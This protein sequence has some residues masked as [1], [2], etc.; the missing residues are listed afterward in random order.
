MTTVR[1]PVRI[2]IEVAE[3]RIDG[4]LVAYVCDAVDAAVSRAVTRAQSVRAIATGRP[5]GREACTTVRFT[6]D[7][8]PR[9]IADAL[10][11]S[12][13]TGLYVAGE[14]LIRRAGGPYTKDEV[15]DTAGQGE[16]RDD[17]R[18]VFD[19]GGSAEYQVPYYDRG[20]KPMAVR[21]HGLAR[22]PPGTAQPP[23]PLPVRLRRF[24]TD[25]ELWDAIMA[26]TGGHPPAR[27]VAIRADDHGKN[28]WADFINI[29]PG[30][31]GQLSGRR[32]GAGPLNL[33][34]FP[35]GQ[36]EAVERPVGFVNADLWS[37]FGHATGR[38]QVRNLMIDMVSVALLRSSPKDPEADVRKRA[39]LVIDDLPYKNATSL[40]LY[41]LTSLGYLV[42]V[43]PVT[44]GGPIPGDTRPAL[45]FTEDDPDPPEDTYGKNCP[46]LDDS[47]PS[48]WL[49]MLGL[50]HPSPSAPE[51]PFLGEP[52]IE[53]WPTAIMTRLD[54]KVRAIA[55]MLHMA[56]GTF[57]GGFLIAALAHVDRNCRILTSNRAP[58]WPQIQAMA[59]AFLPIRE[60]YQEYITIMLSQDQVRA[61]PCPVAGQAPEWGLRFAEVFASARDDAVAS[62]FVSTCQD[63]LL[64][65][66]YA[67]SHELSSRAQSFSSYMPITRML[68]TV[69]L[70]DTVELMDLRDAVIARE[71]KEATA[72]IAT[73][74]VLGGPTIGATWL[75]F[76][77]SLLDS[78]TQEPVSREPTAGTVELHRDGYR[79]YD[80]MGQWWSRAELDAVITAQR[81]QVS[82]VD[83]LLD[84]V[85]EIDD[86]VRQLKAAQVLDANAST[87]LGHQLTAHVDDIFRDLLS[88][89]LKENERWLL[90]A[91]TDRKL[92]FGLANFTRDDVRSASDIGAK[93]AGIH[94]LADERLRPAFS[95]Q[96]AYVAGMSRLAAEE[97]GKAELT[98]ILSLVGL[99]V[100][101][102]FCPLLA[103]G[104]SLVQ[105]AEGLMT[106]F[107][108]RDLQ[109][110]MLNGDEILS[111]AQVEAEMWAAVINAA[112]TVLPELPSLARG[113]GSA[114]RA[115]VRGEATEAAAAATRQAMRNIA[116][117]L[118][119]LG[120]EHFTTRFAKELVQAY[121]I[122]LALSKAMNRIAEAVARQVGVAGH[123]SKGDVLEV[124]SSAIAGSPEGTP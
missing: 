113:A 26:R 50:T 79:V 21:L 60:L 95:D 32:T 61:L 68:L 99:T 92:A 105:A 59:A 49:A 117:H 73:G 19:D 22:K 2:R 87:V 15:I 78:V 42:W 41:Q 7:P 14:R 76:T 57:V 18:V 124:L 4:R 111:K 38:D 10:E 12:M 70:S 62:M 108:H 6:G 1:M 55:G 46:R 69:M 47:E 116:K 118:A 120:I 33:Y 97:I 82:A 24:R 106:A 83:P 109:R 93:L 88:G 89:L 96:D 98:E 54:Q 28:A 39:A 9:S 58:M 37:V 91:A 45:V 64:Q 112:L 71:G 11:T 94:K 115:L 27:L 43:G 102:I 20:A 66:L 84:K 52:A 110:A 17:D 72:A 101:A 90:K 25:Q 13:C 122:N 114:T 86:L 51:I 48:M 74:A 56:P 107:E 30:A 103:F 81:Q 67:S 80:G 85:S 123:A 23:P 40:T 63:I 100:L 119:E 29:E 3:D 53:H 5:S 36:H 31:D 77:E 34:D 104:V 65:V 35:G 75:T 44:A 8:L 16:P 121:L